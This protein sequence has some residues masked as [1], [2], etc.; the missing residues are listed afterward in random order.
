MTMS[1]GDDPKTEVKAVADQGDDRADAFAAV[2]VILLLV[3][4][5]TTFVAT[6]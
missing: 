3:A 2:G 4:L 6:Q 1:Y 5:E